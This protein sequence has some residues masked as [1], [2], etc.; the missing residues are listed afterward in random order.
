MNLLFIGDIFGEPGRNAV[1]DLVP[2]LRQERKIDFVIGNGENVAHG[3]GITQKTAEQLFAAGIDVITTGNH[4]FDQ[5]EVHDYFRRQPKLLRPVNYG[6]AS[7]GRGHVV[8]EVYAG[9]KVGVINLA[10]RINMEPADCPFAAVDRILAEMKG[11]ADI[12]FV[13]MH[14][15]ATSESRAMGWHLDGKVAA[16]VGSH[17]H[18]QTADEEVMPKGTAFLTDAGMT[19]P[20]RSVIGMRIDN[21]LRKFQTGIKSR[22][23]PAEGDV[24]FCGALVEVEESTGLARKIERIQIRL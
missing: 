22:F 7:P 15:E 5:H 18:V 13:D 17:T 6:A 8:V 24:R 23:D 20:Y 1:Q 4:A 11:S 9:V 3:K 10:G 14:A 2:K 12:V 16:V 19:G 21:V